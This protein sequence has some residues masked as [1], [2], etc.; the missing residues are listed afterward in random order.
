MLGDNFFGEN[1]IKN[2]DFADFEK[3]NG[4]IIF[5]KEV[6]N[7]SEFGVAEVDSKGKVMH[8]EEKPKIQIV[9]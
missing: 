1:P 4:S 6:D 3:N 8:I 5:T 9:I 2:I 7:P